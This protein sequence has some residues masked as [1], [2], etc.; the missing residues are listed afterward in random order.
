MTRRI[1]REPGTT[2]AKASGG[3]PPK[4]RDIAINLL[5]TG[6]GQ[7][8]TAASIDP[9]ELIKQINQIN[10]LAKHGGRARSGHRH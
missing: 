3:R 5:V 4:R 8:P 1:E 9:D 6:E 10:E 7:D 2:R